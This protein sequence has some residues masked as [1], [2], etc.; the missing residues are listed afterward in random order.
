MHTERM[1]LVVPNAKNIILIVRLLCEL[2]FFREA[3]LYFELP[4]FLSSLGI[5]EIWRLSRP[6]KWVNYPVAPLFFIRISAYCLRDYVSLVVQQKSR[7][8]AAIATSDNTVPYNNDLLARSLPSHF[9]GATH[10]DYRTD[11]IAE[12]QRPLVERSYR[13]RI[14]NINHH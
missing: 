1:T 12:Q 2:H 8:A 13:N 14:Y 7:Q 5:V 10:D 9:E 3:K 6:S 4:V 11:G